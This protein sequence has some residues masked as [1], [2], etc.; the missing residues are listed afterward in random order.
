MPAPGRNRWSEWWEIARERHEA[1]RV[2]FNN[3]FEAC[4]EEPTLI[5]QTP[6]V[7]YTTY[8]VGLLIAALMVRA[9]IEAIQPIPTDAM[10]PRADTAHFDVICTNPDCGR[11]FIIDRKFGYD[12]FPVRCPYCNQE[13]GRHALRCNSDRCRGRLVPTIESD[14]E[15]RCPICGEPIGE[16]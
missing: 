15:Y 7:R 9:V 3:W 6:A 11:H 2:G 14:G 5:W 8:V 12:N 4:R 13:S 10:T 16:R 1:V